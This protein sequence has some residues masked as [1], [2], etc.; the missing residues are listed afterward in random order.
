MIQLWSRSLRGRPHLSHRGTTGQGAQW[1]GESSR[2]SY[3]PL[4]R[5]AYPR[6]LIGHPEMKFWFQ[7]FGGLSHLHRLC[8]FIL[9]VRIVASSLP[10]N[11]LTPLPQ[12]TRSKVVWERHFNYKAPKGTTNFFIPKGQGINLLGKMFQQFVFEKSSVFPKPLSRPIVWLG[13]EKYF[14]QWCPSGGEIK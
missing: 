13:C 3:I 5:C 4:F 10:E 11:S 1:V 6:W 9:W 14:C 12:E 2:W 7:K 8:D